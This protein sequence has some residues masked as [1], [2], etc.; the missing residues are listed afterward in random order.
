MPQE[1][2]AELLN[3]SWQSDKRWQGIKRP[4]SAEDVMKLSGSI[5][6]EHTLARMGAERL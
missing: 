3:K 6:V 2:H 1:R 5:R 4:Y